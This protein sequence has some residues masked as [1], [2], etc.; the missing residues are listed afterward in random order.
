MTL[1]Y[2]ISRQLRHQLGGTAD[3]KAHEKISPYQLHALHT[4]AHNPLTM[5]ELAEE[6]NITLSS[7]TAL[8]DRLVKNRW[9]ERREDPE[10]RR[11]VRLVITERGRELY[12]TVKRERYKAFKFLLDAMPPEDVAALRRIFTNLHTTLQNRKTNEE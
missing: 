4:L 11:I 1:A 8:V 10:D 9:V 5:G 7:A 3:E 2:Q 12:R 6:M